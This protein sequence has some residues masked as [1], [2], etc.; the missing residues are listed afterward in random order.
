MGGFCVL[1][2]N[3]W[4]IWCTL[5]PTWRLI[6]DVFQ[7]VYEGSWDFLP[8]APCNG[9][10]TNLKVLIAQVSLKI[11]DHDTV[12]NRY[13]RI[14]SLCVVLAAAVTGVLWAACGFQYFC[15]RVF[16]SSIEGYVA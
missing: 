8:V 2:K 4:G 15:E 9:I 12:E 10:E 3:M 7:L 6:A 1:Q 16:V 13:V 14:H 5:L 11:K